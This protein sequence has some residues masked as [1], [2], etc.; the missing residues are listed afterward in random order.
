MQIFNV[1]AVY[2]EHLVKLTLKL[3]FFLACETPNPLNQ[4][5]PSDRYSRFLQN[6]F[7]RSFL[8]FFL[9]L[10]VAMFELLWRCLF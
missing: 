3:L 6:E 9:L 2:F 8:L 10:C 4:S 5:L 1:I 7:Y